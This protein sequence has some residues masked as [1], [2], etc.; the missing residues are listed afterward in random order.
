MA[1]YS[2]GKDTGSIGAHPSYL[3]SFNS[4]LGPYRETYNGLR[5][6]SSGLTAYDDTADNIITHIN[7]YNANLDKILTIDNASVDPDGST[8]VLRNADGDGYF[9]N[10]TVAA[11][12][13]VSNGNTPAGRIDGGRL[14][15]LEL[16]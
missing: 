10:L 13:I 8:I 11:L 15:D 5:R 14:E 7:N 9:N 12:T 6:T 2:N 16:L 3:D 4:S 1:N